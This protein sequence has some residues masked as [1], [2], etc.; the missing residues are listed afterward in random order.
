MKTH[1]SSPLRSRSE[2]LRFGRWC[3]RPRVLGYGLFGL[4]ILATLLGVLYLVINW[5]GQR[6]WQRAE[7]ALKARGIETDFAVYVPARIPDADNFALHP[8]FK[9]LFDFKEGTQEW[10]DREAYQR[11]TE[12]GRALAVRTGLANWSL[13][14]P[15]D[16]RLWWE[17]TPAGEAT[18]TNA[19]DVGSALGPAATA[20]AVQELL[21]PYGAEL[22]DLIASVRG[23]RCRF[24]V[25]YDAEPVF[26][27]LLPHLAELRKV[28]LLAR[29]RAEACLVEGDTRGAAA[30]VLFLLDLC[31]TVKSEP[32]LISQLVRCVIAEDAISLL[33]QGMREHRWDTEQLEVF[34]NRL[35]GLAFQPELHRA[36]MAEHAGG[37][38]AID[39][40]RRAPGLFAAML[41]EGDGSDYPMS[42]GLLWR[43]IPQGW[44]DYEKVEFSR[45]YT[46][47]TI[48]PTTGEAGRIDARAV[49]RAQSELEQD[50][51]LNPVERVL[52]HRVLSSMLVPA[53]GRVVQRTV[54]AE[55]ATG[56]TG[57]ACALE[58]Y[59]LA[60]GN[61]PDALDTLVGG[62]VAAL[63]LDPLTGK[64]FLYRKV[65]EERFV[66]Y[67]VGWNLED[68]GGRVVQD[69]TARRVKF[70]EGDWVF[71]FD[72]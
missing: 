25:A 8:F 54:F 32:L 9:P 71:Q 23:K 36:L 28:G 30:A 42:L 43:A 57:A 38:R 61:Y 66:L 21:R 50:L 16:L 15:T 37:L 46:V 68:E 34:E 26:G 17:S 40:A 20:R 24:P 11:R 52:R 4:A 7:A 14:V 27:I 10:R 13:A 29:I 5:R 35:A 56:M 22:D 47:S 69:K 3:R 39:E 65:S 12:H 62:T 41:E 6:A 58:R 51:T 1:E 33:W 49:G 2:L 64:P 67:S 18:G 31:D 72:R 63:P 53:L 55:A 70:T 48:E 60:N 44:F 19:Q 59:R 45:L